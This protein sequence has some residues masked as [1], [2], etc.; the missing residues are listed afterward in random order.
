[1]AA[2][3]SD[4]KDEGD[5]PPDAVAASLRPTFAPISSVLVEKLSSAGEL[6]GV[7]DGARELQREVMK[8]G[9]HVSSVRGE[10]AD[11]ATPIDAGCSSRS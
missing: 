3:T 6:R 7:D 1:V 9:I 11:G 4:G 10:V 8:E 2:A 5:G